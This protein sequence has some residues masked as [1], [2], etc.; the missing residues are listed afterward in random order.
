[1]L[2]IKHVYTSKWKR[3]QLAAVEAAA[4]KK[5]SAEDHPSIARQAKVSSTQG[6]VSSMDR[7][8]PEGGQILPETSRLAL[9]SQKRKRSATALMPD[10]DT[11]SPTK[12]PRLPDPPILT[13][14]SGDVPWE[15]RNLNEVPWYERI[16]L[17]LYK[18]GDGQERE[19]GDRSPMSPMSPGGRAKERATGI[20]S[21]HPVTS[22]DHKP[23]VRSTSSYSPPLESSNNS[24][25]EASTPDERDRR[26]RRKAKETIARRAFAKCRKAKAEADRWDGEKKSLGLQ[27]GQKASDAAIFATEGA[28]ANYPGA[29]LSYVRGDKK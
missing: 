28:Q 15:D 6:I 29:R 25:D 13:G 3:T 16:G 21:K 17:L 27:R 10:N 18:D 8:A 20:P 22:D 23:L 5:P 1:M 14:N 2:K 12:I 7:P 4:N 26:R 9:T 24:D 11:T 19:G